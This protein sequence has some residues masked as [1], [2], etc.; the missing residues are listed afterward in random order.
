MTV[1]N[2]LPIKCVL[3]K[4]RQDDKYRLIID[5]RYF[6]KKIQSK[7]K[8]LMTNIHEGDQILQVKKNTF[9]IE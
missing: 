8:N 3:N 6:I 2:D 9:S 1:D 4:T 5:C 7:N